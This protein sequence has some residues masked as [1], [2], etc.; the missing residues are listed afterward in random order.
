MTDKKNTTYSYKEVLEKSTEY[1]NGDDLAASTWANKYAMKDADGN[2]LELTPDDMHQRMATEFARIEE[3]YRINNFIE[4][5][6]EALSDY[7]KKRAPLSFEK[8]YN[9]Y[10]V[11]SDN[12]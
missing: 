3:Y 10:D 12:S 7:G 11:G 1:F 5:K 9:F 2:Y 4:G 8:I 6:Q